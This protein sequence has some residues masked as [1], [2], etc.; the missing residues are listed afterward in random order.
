MR[1]TC[2]HGEDDPTT[3]RNGRESA[4]QR[5]DPLRQ[6]CSIGPRRFAAPQL[7]SGVPILLSQHREV[8]FANGSFVDY[9]K[10]WQQGLHIIGVGN[11]GEV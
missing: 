7:H 10:L 1:R 11:H 9:D 3:R 2:L 8:M 6:E 4:A 5:F